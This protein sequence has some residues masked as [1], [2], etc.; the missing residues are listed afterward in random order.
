MGWDGTEQPSHPRSSPRCSEGAAPKT[1]TLSNAT[2]TQTATLQ[3]PFRSLFSWRIPFS[4]FNHL[5]EDSGSPL[6]SLATRGAFSETRKAFD[7]NSEQ[8]TNA[9]VP[10]CICTHACLEGKTQSDPGQAFPQAAGPE[11]WCL[12][13][14]R[15]S[16]H[17]PP[18]DAPSPVGTL[19]TAFTASFRPRR[20]LKQ[21]GHF[22][23]SFKHQPSTFKSTTARGQNAPPAA[24]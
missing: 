22:L 2:A 3:G 19:T 8:A 23:F 16:P 17:R 15:F 7:P 13:A 5:P 20:P 12:A 4:G 21:A 18:W 24:Y 10:A 9:F 11:G 14:L 1:P 6:T